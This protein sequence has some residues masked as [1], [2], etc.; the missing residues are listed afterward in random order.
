[1]EE[2]LRKF[3]PVK[4]P[5][6]LRERILQAATREVGRSFADRWLHSGRFWI[7]IAAALVVSVALHAVAAE[8]SRIPDLVGAPRPARARDPRFEELERKSKT[9][10]MEYRRNPP[11]GLP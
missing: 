8:W 11:E 9:T 6:E 10:L 4:P 1:M 3:E 7:G 5:Q 2:D